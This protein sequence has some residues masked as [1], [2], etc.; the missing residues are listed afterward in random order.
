LGGDKV[1]PSDRER[2]IEKARVNPF[3]IGVG[4]LGGSSR[5]LQR[6]VG[7][8]D[9]S[10]PPASG[11]QPDGIGSLAAPNIERGTWSEVTYFSDKGTIRFTA[12]HLF[13]VS[14]PLVPINVASTDWLDVRMVSASKMVTARLWRIRWV[15]HGFPILPR[16]PQGR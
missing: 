7:H 11:C 13:S 3:H 10:D 2:R 15:G 16:E 5:T 8:V 6:D 1:E 4:L 9:R 12:P 14:V